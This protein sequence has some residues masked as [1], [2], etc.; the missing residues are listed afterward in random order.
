MAIYGL[1]VSDYTV[2]Q[3]LKSVDKMHRNNKKYEMENSVIFLCRQTS[4][5]LEHILL[6]YKRQDIPVNIPELARKKK[7]TYRRVR[8]CDVLQE[9]CKI[10]QPIRQTQP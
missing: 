10:V 3:A 2:V 7:K 9:I 6:G 5:I 4:G 1:H 8:L